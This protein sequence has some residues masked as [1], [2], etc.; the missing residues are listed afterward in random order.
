M[1]NCCRNPKIESSTM[2][3]WCENCGWYFEYNSNTEGCD[4]SL[5][6]DGYG[7]DDDDDDYDS[8]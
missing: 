1:N 8:F 3:D 4:L 6:D 5:I 7:Y 2:A